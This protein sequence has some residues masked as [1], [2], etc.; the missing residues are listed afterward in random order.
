MN[1]LETL[2]EIL[3]RLEELNQKLQEIPIPT[4]E[5]IYR[6]HMSDL[7]DSEES[8]MYQLRLLQEAHFIF[9]IHI[10]EPDD[11]LMIPGIYGYVVAKNEI[12]HPLVAEY[13][14]RLE[15]VYEAQLFKRKAASTIIRELMPEVKQYNNTPLGQILNISIMLEQYVRLIAEKPEEYE[16]YWKQVK[17]RQLLPDLEGVESV[18]MPG[19][20]DLTSDSDFG[21]EDSKGPAEKVVRRAVDTPEYQ[22]LARMDLS[23]S[24]GKAVEKYGVVFLMRVHLRKMEFDTLKRLMLRRRIT[25]E[26]D[27]RYLRDS[28]R[29]MEERFSLDRSMAHMIDPVRELKRIAQ[30][31]LNQF[32]ILRKKLEDELDV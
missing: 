6:R 5:D 16:D 32:T 28:L 7:H 23:G 8:L 21:D 13:H 19:F 12:L 2:L 1:T 30:I 20:G 26:E 9:M 4:S 29:V 14:R 3:K 10:V 25:R 18:D 17:L 27:L 22:E 15:Q 31:R 24:W 11:R